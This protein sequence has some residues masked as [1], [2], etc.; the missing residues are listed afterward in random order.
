MVEANRDTDDG[1][2]ELADQHAERTPDEQWST[3]ELLDGVEG[4]GGGAHVDECEDEGDQ[5]G[6]ADGTSRLEEGSRV[7]ENEVDTSPLL[8]H[9]KRGTENGAAQVGL[10]MPQTAGETVLPAGK[11]ASGWDDLA[12]V[13]LVGDNL[14][15]L[16][17]DILRALGLATESRERVCCGLK[18][19]LFDKVSRRVWE[20]GETTAE[21]YGPCELDGDGNSVCARV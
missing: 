18:I 11:P 5:E 19:A 17:A 2:K 10:L 20:E 16:N 14:G 7:V 12:F 3:A 6:V 1:D 4:D 8:H 9:L 21:N 15:K 13:L